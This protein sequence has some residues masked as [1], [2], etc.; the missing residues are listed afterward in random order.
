MKLTIK[1]LSFTQDNSNFIIIII[2]NAISFSHKQELNL[3]HT[4]SNT[5]FLF[6]FFTNKK[7][8]T[9]TRTMIIN[10]KTKLTFLDGVFY[11]IIAISDIPVHSK[12]NL[13]HAHTD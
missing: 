1:R 6:F 11:D 7:I 2:I 3:N 8:V 4:N 9:L 5:A 12:N 10:Q 13:T